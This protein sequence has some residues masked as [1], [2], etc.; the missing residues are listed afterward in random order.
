M[1]T[2]APP[3]AAERIFAA[4]ATLLHRLE[5][6]SR[7]DRTSLQAAMTA[8]FGG[9]DAAGR[10]VWK[11][12]YEAAETAVTLMLRRYGA[13]MLAQAGTAA[14]MLR[15]VERLAD[16]EPAQTRRDDVQR[17]FE[18]FSTPLAL[19]WVAA[20]AADVQPGDVVLEPSAERSRP[21]PG[22]GSTRPRAGGWS[23]TSSPP[24]ARACC[25]W[26]SPRATSPA[27]TPS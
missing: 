11:Q 26:R 5:A 23:S 27:T 14:G 17:R 25:A 2:N 20:A 9:T 13:A 22:P 10:W 4:A 1:H 24:P 16:L 7:L 6:G 15:L 12:A 18:Q 8:A 21:R 3:G 19:A